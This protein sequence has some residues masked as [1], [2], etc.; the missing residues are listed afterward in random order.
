MPT[1]RITFGVEVEAVKLT[2]EAKSLI[3]KHGFGQH[4]D[5]TIR[6]QNGEELPSSVEAGG[7]CE[8]VTRPLEARVS[9]TDSCGNGY[10][11]NFGDSLGVVQDLCKC[12][13]E[14]NKSCGV[15]L[16]LGKPS[17]SGVSSRW[18]RNDVR[19]MLVVGRWYEEKLFNLC[20]ETR[21]LNQY[22]KTIG[23]S[24]QTEDFV[25][26]SPLGEVNPR[27]YSNSKRYCWLNAIETERSG[28]IGTIEIR[29]L[30]NVRRFS[31]IKSW[32]EL[33]TKI[34]AFVA[35]A[36][37]V[38]VVAHAQIL[39][40]FDRQF[41]AVMEAK[42]APSNKPAPAPSD[43]RDLRKKKKLKRVETLCPEYPVYSAM[44]TSVTD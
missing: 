22:C 18:S 19:L 33:W 44:S 26:S 3:D 12:V 8:L 30:G 36:D 20:P 42:K 37:P 16:H 23:D 40:T 29:M 5:R 7:G 6:G 11:S 31:Y 43:L 4:Y 1:H 39:G 32:V 2:G 41:E 27:K 15:H 14:V 24:F 21:K 25:S 13:L 10:S 28:G 17:G 34:S 9:F 35:Y 38:S